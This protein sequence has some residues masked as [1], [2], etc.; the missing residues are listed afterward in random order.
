MSDIEQVKE[1]A[2][3]ICDSYILLCKAFRI[4]ES[5]YIKEMKDNAGTQSAGYSQACYR[6][7]NDNGTELL[8]DVI[9]LKSMLLKI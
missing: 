8:N 4:S 2:N 9:E 1:I 3:K 7:L 6:I 5:D